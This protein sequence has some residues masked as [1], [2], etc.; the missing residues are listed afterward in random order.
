M[1]AILDVPVLINRLIE[2][3]PNCEGVD[4]DVITKI[5]ETAENHLLQLLREL[6]EIA[7]HRTEPLR[8]NP[9]YQQINDPRKQLKFVEEYEKKMFELRE[10]AA[11]RETHAKSSKTKA[12]EGN[13]KAKE[14]SASMQSVSSSHYFH[15]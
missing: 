4:R 13:L 3:V 14:V 1:S 5:S 8:T 6:S 9:L 11:D 7:G 12:K 10:I 15:R 2:Q